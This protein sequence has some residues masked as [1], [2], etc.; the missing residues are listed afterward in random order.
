M[1]LL[2]RVS[3]AKRNKREQSKSKLASQK[4]LRFLK[5]ETVPL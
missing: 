1:K 5:F 4:R 3:S 2:L